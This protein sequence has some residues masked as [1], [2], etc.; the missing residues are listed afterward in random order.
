M[1]DVSIFQEQSPSLHT[2]QKLPSMESEMLR[3]AK[4]SMNLLQLP[5]HRQSSETM[6]VIQSILHMSIFKIP[7]WAKK[8]AFSHIR[9]TGKLEITV[10]HKPLTDNTLKYLKEMLNMLYCLTLWGREREIGLNMIWVMTHP[11]LCTNLGTMEQSVISNDNQINALIC[12]LRVSSFNWRGR[13]T[14]GH[15]KNWNVRENR[16]ALIT[17]Y[18]HEVWL[19]AN[20]G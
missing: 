18:L 13:D 19:N 5:N 6:L 11:E 3:N 1:K 9:S 17:Y 12:L 15:A 10:Q 2:W 20:I 16:I 4:F 8:C 7:T 14:I